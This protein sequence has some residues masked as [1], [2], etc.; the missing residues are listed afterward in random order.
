MFRSGFNPFVNSAS[1]VSKKII[2]L[3]G[4]GEYFEV[5]HSKLNV[6]IIGI[7]SNHLLFF[8]FYAPALLLIDVSIFYLHRSKYI[9]YI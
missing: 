8:G 4:L 7:F 3:V 2:A 5:V 6:S 9:D 1:K